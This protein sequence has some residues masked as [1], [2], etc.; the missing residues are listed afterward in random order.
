MSKQVITGYVAH[1]RAGF[2][3]PG[4]LMYRSCNWYGELVN[5]LIYSRLRKMTN[6]LLANVLATYDLMSPSLF[7]NEIKNHGK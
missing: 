4:T 1:S 6:D 5:V 3:L 7:K 2:L